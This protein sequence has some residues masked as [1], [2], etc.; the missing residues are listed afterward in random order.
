MELTQ[1]KL[2]T[3]IAE[4]VLEERL[5]RE[6]KTLGAKGFTVLASSGE[7]SRGIRAGEIPGENV[8]IETVVSAEV[9]ERIMEHVST[10]Y[11]KHYAIICFISEVAVLRGEK[12]S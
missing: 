11:F 4:S 8:R 1:R 10:H 9:A 3:I 2:V 7:G 5:C 6:L 12:Y